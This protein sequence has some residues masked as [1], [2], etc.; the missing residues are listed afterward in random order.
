VIYLLMH[1][2]S[3]KLLHYVFISIG[4]GRWW[5]ILYQ[6][7]RVVLAAEISS[8]G[9]SPSQ[10]RTLLLTI[11]SL[12]ATLVNSKQYRYSQ[13][14]SSPFV[15]S[16]NAETILTRIYLIHIEN[17]KICFN[18]VLVLGTCGMILYPHHLRRYWN[19]NSTWA[20]FVR[21]VNVV[22]DWRSA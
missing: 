22:I 3:N 11:W 10:V 4:T 7:G 13:W 2:N 5:P 20:F 14:A 21:T 15:T 8:T 18:F 17:Q 1:K 12:P 16:K 6:H 19:N 9:Q